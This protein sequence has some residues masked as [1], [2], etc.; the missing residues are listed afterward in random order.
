MIIVTITL[1]VLSLETQGHIV[2]MRTKSEQA[3]K[4]CDERKYQGK[5]RAPG[6]KLHMDQFQSTEQILD[7]DWAE[8]L[9]YF[10]AQS[11]NSQTKTPFGVFFNT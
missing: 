3:R 1:R 7:P 4:K 11:S 9:L 5:I 8:I 10:S 2:R 6:N